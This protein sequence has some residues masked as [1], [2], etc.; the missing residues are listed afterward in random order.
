MH[1]YIHIFYECN[2]LFQVTILVFVSALIWVNYN[3]PG[4]IRL[5]GTNA[6]FRTQAFNKHSTYSSGAAI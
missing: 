5:A 3:N 4:Y 2:A 6:H 1:L